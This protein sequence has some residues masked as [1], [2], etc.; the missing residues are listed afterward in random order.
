MEEHENLYDKIKEILGGMSGSVKILEQKIDLDLQVEYYDCS[1]KM[2]KE[3]DDQWAREQIK[4][5]ND[6]EYS[7]DAKK[8][9][10]ARL[11][12]VD[13]VGCYRA[14]EHYMESADE[15]TRDWGFLALN[16]SRMHLESKILGENQVFISTGLGGREEKLR[17]F[18]V[19]ISRT[20]AEFDTTQKKVIENEFE[21]T[22]K[23]Y[24][25]ELEK[26]EFSDQLATILLLLP[27]NYPLKMVFREAIEECNQYGNFLREEFIVTNVKTLT[28]KEIKEYLKNKIRKD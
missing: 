18:V 11:A 19:V 22:L 24:D 27:M 20:G 7:S 16:E 9:I 17:Y 14:I 28:F 21:F 25:A 26:V 6:P 5:L 3:K 1:R 4:N 15:Q 8:E 12:T 10:L 23:K 13:D 2:R